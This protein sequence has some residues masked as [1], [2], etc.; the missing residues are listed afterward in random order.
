MQNKRIRLH[1]IYVKDIEAEFN[2]T[3][4]TV[5][6]SLQYVFNSELSKLIRKRAKDLLIKEANKIED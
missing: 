5:R 4:Q 6:M 2:C 1:P 3:A